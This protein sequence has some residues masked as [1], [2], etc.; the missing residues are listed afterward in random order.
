MSDEVKPV[1]TEEAPKAVP[2]QPATLP[3]KPDLK[4]RMYANLKP[5]PKL[6][7]QNRQFFD[8]ADY[9]AG[10]KTGDKPVKKFC[11]FFFELT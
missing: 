10:K 7:D 4:A 1:K 5:K 2:Q 9:F 3:A 6:M 11:L 8:S